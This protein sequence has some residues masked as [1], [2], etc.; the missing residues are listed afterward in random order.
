MVWVG[1]R[2][3]PERPFFPPLHKK[4]MGT[5]D[6]NLHSGR[7]GAMQGRAGNPGVVR[8]HGRGTRQPTTSLAILIE[9]EGNYTGDCGDS[10]RSARSP[11]TFPD[12]APRRACAHHT[13]PACVPPCLCAPRR[14]E[15]FDDLSEINLKRSP[16]PGVLRTTR[17]YFAA[18]PSPPCDRRGNPFLPFP[19]FSLSQGGI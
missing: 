6:M 3:M 5:E 9:T 4:S 12:E 18:P 11:Y 13:V 1:A 14:A 8:R 15:T 16:S 19:L 7:M 2:G 10:V 17:S